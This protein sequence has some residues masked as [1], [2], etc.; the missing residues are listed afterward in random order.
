MLIS[1]SARPSS[2]YACM[3]YAR[4]YGQ[5]W[6]EVIRIDGDMRL[7]N[8]HNP[9]HIL[10]LQVCKSCLIAKPVHVWAIS[11]IVWGFHGARPGSGEVNTVAVTGR[12]A[13]LDLPRLH[14]IYKVL[15]IVYISRI[16][17]ISALMR[18]P[19]RGFHAPSRIDHQATFVQTN[20]GLSQ[21]GH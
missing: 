16:R 7:S 13:V 9:R 4:K 6:M 8:W 2:T 20:H 17:M 14:R 18:D 19:W 11:L 1:H 3:T 15:M 21:S 12:A 5:P 10:H